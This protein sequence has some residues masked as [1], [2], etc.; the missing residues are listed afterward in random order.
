MPAIDARSTMH[1]QIFD[2]GCSVDNVVGLYVRRVLGVRLMR[3][4]GCKSERRP[5][6]MGEKTPVEGDN[7]CSGRVPLTTPLL[8]IFRWLR[9]GRVCDVNIPTGD[10]SF[11]VGGYG[12]DLEAIT[13][14]PLL[15]GTLVMS[16]P[17]PA[18]RYKR[19]LSFTAL[20]GKK[21]CRLVSDGAGL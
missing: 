2:C 7:W 19:G 4:R 10:P 20:W 13:L 9:V 12:Y 15:E 11:T 6:G 14:A 16:R 21:K 18:P 5:I 17:V 1:A 8:G 3:L